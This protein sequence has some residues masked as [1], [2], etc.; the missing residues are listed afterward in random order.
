M[1]VLQVNAS[2]STCT[3]S[4][5][6]S[7]H[8]LHSPV[9]VWMAVWHFY[10]PGPPSSTHTDFPGK[11]QIY[12][13]VLLHKEDGEWVIVQQVYCTLAN[14]SVT[15]QCRHRPHP[16]SSISQNLPTIWQM[17]MW[18]LYS[19]WRLL[20]YKV[21]HVFLEIF[22]KTE[23]AAPIND[24]LIWL[25]VLCDLSRACRCLSRSASSVTYCI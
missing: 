10:S 1:Y 24:P 3:T 17:T 15:S 23:L 13:Y 7:N 18:V 8:Y 22:L 25:C 2:V 6:T 21:L 19:Q 20:G 12:S 16:I 14:I 9:V 5:H 4:N 11:S